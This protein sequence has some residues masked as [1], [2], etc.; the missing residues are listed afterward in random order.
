MTLVQLISI[1]AAVVFLVAAF[2]IRFCKQKTIGNWVELLAYVSLVVFSS[3]YAGYIVNIGHL[4]QGQ[5]TLLLAFVFSVS[6][7]IY[8][9]LFLTFLQKR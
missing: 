5:W 6:L 1:I 3:R 2:I 7:L 9:L 4:E 8:K